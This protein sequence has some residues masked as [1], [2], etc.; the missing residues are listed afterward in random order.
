MYLTIGA[1][2]LLVGQ[3][4]DRKVK[5]LEVNFDYLFSSYSSY[6]RFAQVIA[7]VESNT[8]KIRLKSDF[9]NTSDCIKLAQLLIGLEKLVTLQ[10]MALLSDILEANS[11]ATPQDFVDKQADLLEYFL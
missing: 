11:Q 3:Y 8:L 9:K 4:Q 5:K 2:K 1:T 7:D 10:N 6:R